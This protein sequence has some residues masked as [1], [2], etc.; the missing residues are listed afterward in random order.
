MTLLRRIDTDYINASVLLSA[1]SLSLDE[2]DVVLDDINDSFCVAGGGAP[3][4]GV[5]IPLAEAQK[6]ATRFDDELGQLLTF[7]S[8]DLGSLFVEPIPTST[9]LFAITRQSSVCL[10]FSR[11]AV[12]AGLRAALASSPTTNVA[13]FGHPTFDETVGADDAEQAIS[14]RAPTTTTTNKSRTRS[15]SSSL[16]NASP[17]KP[18]VTS[19]EGE[20]DVV[21]VVDMTE[22]TTARKSRRVSMTK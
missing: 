15:L 3:V 20:K 5:W 7:L 4:E 8:E 18:V 22:G 1:T 13:L 11:L 14:P 9:L 21:K 6:L 19:E 12:R 2:R 16:Q 10:L 17:R